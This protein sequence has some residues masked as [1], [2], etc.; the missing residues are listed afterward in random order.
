VPKKTELVRQI[1]SLAK[2]YGVSARLKRQGSHEIWECAG[3]TFPIPRH[4]EIAEGT[5]RKI[6]K[7]L[8]EHLESLKDGQDTNE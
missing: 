2:Q 6:I 4:R 3:Y 5:A 7:A 1:R 8:T